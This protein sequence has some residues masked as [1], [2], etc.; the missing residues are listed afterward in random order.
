[1]EVGLCEGH[2]WSS[3]TIHDPRSIHDHAFVTTVKL[4]GSHGSTKMCLSS[5]IHSIATLSRK[6]TMWPGWS[7]AARWRDAAVRVGS[8]RRASVDVA[9]AR[10]RGYPGPCQG[11]T[12]RGQGS[13]EWKETDIND[14]NAAQKPS[15][16]AL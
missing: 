7:G 16:G 1:M 15:I 5:S 11:A 13:K 8:S 10:L 2:A 14:D 6:R 12:G 9:L 4:Y 3:S